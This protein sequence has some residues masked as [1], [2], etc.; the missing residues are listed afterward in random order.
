MGGVAVVVFPT[1]QGAVLCPVFNV[2]VHRTCARHSPDRGI[3]M[4]LKSIFKA[5]TIA[6]E[7]K[8]SYVNHWL[9]VSTSEI[10]FTSLI[11]DCLMINESKLFTSSCVI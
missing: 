2:S 1:R 3:T 8:L 11:V 10:P 6:G 5:L 7:N 9:T 4:K